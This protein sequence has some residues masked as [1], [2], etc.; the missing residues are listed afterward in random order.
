MA[1]FLQEYQN[2]LHFSHRGTVMIPTSFNRTSVGNVS[3]CSSLHLWHAS[4]MGIQF[5][6]IW[7]L[8]LRSKIGSILVKIICNL[9]CLNQKNCMPKQWKGSQYF[10]TLSPKPRYHLYTMCTMFTGSL[11]TA[12]QKQSHETKKRRKNCLQSGIFL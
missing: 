1:H 6:N 11:Y 3:I 8:S 9:L 7:I 4:F 5:Y 10:N 12:N 2:P